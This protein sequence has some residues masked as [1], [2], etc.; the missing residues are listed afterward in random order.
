[1]PKRES[2]HLIHN[3]GTAPVNVPPLFG[4][5][6]A[7]RFEVMKSKH[8]WHHCPVCGQEKL[9]V[10]QKNCKWGHE[11]ICWECFLPKAIKEMKK[12]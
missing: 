11:A 2:G 4:D 1:V 9:C 12:P 5:G 8:H 10:I 6:A 3:G 7:M